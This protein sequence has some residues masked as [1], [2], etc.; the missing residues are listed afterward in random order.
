[1]RSSAAVA[2]RGRESLNDSPVYLTDAERDVLTDAVAIAL[3]NYL[4]R[5]E[6]ELS[7]RAGWYDDLIRVGNKLGMNL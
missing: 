6:P 1:M 7:A 5:V 4:V 3:A 2:E